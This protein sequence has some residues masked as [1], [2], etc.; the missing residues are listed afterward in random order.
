MCSDV[1]CAIQTVTQRSEISFSV[2]H[3]GQFTS[4]Q[5]ATEAVL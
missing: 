4:V 1:L 2:V 5:W 3:S